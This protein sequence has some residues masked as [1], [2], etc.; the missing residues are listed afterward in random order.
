MAPSLASPCPAPPS[1][2]GSPPESAHA[3]QAGA[4][5]SEAL[6]VGSEEQALPASNASASNADRTGAA[7]FKACEAVKVH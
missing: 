7:E 3:S 5:A 2:A 1:F 6:D 4:A